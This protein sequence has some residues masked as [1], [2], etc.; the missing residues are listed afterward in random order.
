MLWHFFPLTVDSLDVFLDSLERMKVAE[1]E[2]TN[3]KYAALCCNGLSFGT[4]DS[5]KR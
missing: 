1:L 5:R 4:C 3:R 2:R